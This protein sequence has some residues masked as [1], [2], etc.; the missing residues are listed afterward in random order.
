MEKTLK[1]IKVAASDESRVDELDWSNGTVLMLIERIETL[2]AEITALREDKARLNEQ[3]ERVNFVAAARAKDLQTLMESRQDALAAK[4]DDA[5]VEPAPAHGIAYV[6][7]DR[8]IVRE[9][10]KLAGMVGSVWDVY[11]GGLK[12]YYTVELDDIGLHTFT[13]AQLDR[14]PVE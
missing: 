4:P 13:H 1:S 7:D 11:K 8:V 12:G 2:T 3:L 5:P 14:E 6:V 10:H 9:G